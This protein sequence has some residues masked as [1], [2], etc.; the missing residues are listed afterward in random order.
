MT[1][2]VN[3][4]NNERKK[5][6]RVIWRLDTCCSFP[7]GLLSFKEIFR[8]LVSLIRFVASSFQDRDYGFYV[9]DSQPLW[10]RNGWRCCL[11]T[12]SRVQFL[13]C[14]VFVIKNLSCWIF[15]EFRD[16][17]EV[18]LWRWSPVEGYRFKKQFFL[19][20]GPLQGCT[21]VYVIK[22]SLM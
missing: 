11:M 22:L 12:K 9:V 5:N 14:R 1:W 21:V 20:L 4:C 18:C 7:P 3:K 2:V 8:C 10:R 17:Y 15:P 6:V 16:S 13:R 19:R